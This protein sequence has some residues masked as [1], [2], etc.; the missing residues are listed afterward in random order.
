MPGRSDKRDA[1]R[2]M[3]VNHRRAGEKINL[4]DLAQQ[5]GVNYDTLRRWK[6]ADRWEEEAFPPKRKRGGQ[7]KNKNAVGNTGG[8]PLRN[9]NA[10]THGGYTSVFFEQLTEDERLIIESPP[11]SAVEALREELGLLKIQEKRILDQIAV[12]EEASPDELYI[13]TLLDMRV[14]G[15]VEGEKK[16]GATQN[17]GMYTKE[18][19]FTRKMHLQEALNKVQGRIATIIGKLQQAEETRARIEIERQRLELMRLR[20]VGAVNVPDDTE[21]SAGDDALYK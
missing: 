6:S 4:R 15:K 16:D 8:A 18:S 17:M 9:Q 14:P 19:A 10:R 1:A 12:L 7:P 11:A 5:M 20:A 21:D 2:E 13:S 3:Y